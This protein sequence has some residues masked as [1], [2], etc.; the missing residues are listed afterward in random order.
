MFGEAVEL[1]LPVHT[2]WTEQDGSLP[3][4]LSK[5]SDEFAN[6]EKGKYK[7]RVSGKI[8]LCKEFFNTR[9]LKTSFGCAVLH[10]RPG[11]PGGGGGGSEG[12]KQEHKPPTLCK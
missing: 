2:R 7:W 12:V 8:D 1:G 6:H 11:M 9:C 5:L 10:I 3:D 4:T